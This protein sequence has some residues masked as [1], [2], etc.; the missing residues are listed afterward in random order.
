LSAFPERLAAPG[1][2][3]V[4][5]GV[6]SG[7]AGVEAR[8]LAERG[9]HLR[10]ILSRAS[11]L[12]GCDLAA[13][14]EAGATESLP[15]RAAQL[16]TCSFSLGLLA[17]LAEQGMSPPRAIA[18][19]SMGLY[20]ALAAV[21]AVSEDDALRL[22]AEAHR[23]ARES[24]A[25]L[26]CGMLSIIGLE[27]PEVE[28]LIA[29][30]PEVCLAIRNGEISHVASGPQAALAQLLAAAQGA[31]ATRATLIER[32]A[33]YHHPRILAGAAKAL[34]GFLDS[35]SWTRARCPLI[36]TVDARAL[37]EPEE[38]KDFTAQ[39]LC[40]PIDWERA[41]LAL[42][43]RGA[44]TL[45]ECGAGTGLSKLGRFIDAPVEYVNLRHL[46]KEGVP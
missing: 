42:S 17:S 44:T 13:S 37:D 24:C 23:L 4:F 25:G 43:A 28:A 27:R 9:R 15:P 41:V 11:K 39:N 16:L 38:L 8:V 2:G 19:H 12:A 5:P 30:V 35:L 1:L 34:R 46:A 20:A 31:G 40:S 22:V 32:E 10:P 21:G 26:P 3:V 29:S 7:L 18:G 14:L 6:A 36:S 45:L 33:P